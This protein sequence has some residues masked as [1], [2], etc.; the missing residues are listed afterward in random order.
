MTASKRRWPLA[1]SPRIPKATTAVI[2]PAGK[3]GTLKSRLSAIA[4]PTNSAR[5][6]AM[7]MSSAWTHRPQVTGRGK[8][9]RHSSGRLRPGGDA[10]LRRQ[11][12]D[13]HRHQ[14]GGEQ[15]PQQQVAVLGAAGDVRREV[16]RVDVGDAGDERGAEHGQRAAQSDRATGPA[17]GE[18]AAAARQ[19]RLARQADRLI[20]ATSTR[21]ARA[22]APPRTWTSSPKRANVGPSK[23]CLSMTSKSSPGAMPALGQVAQHLRVGVRDAHE[24]RARRRLEVGQRDRRRAPSITRSRRRDRVAVRIERGVAELGRDQLLE[25]LGEGVLEHLGLGVDPV[26]RHV[27]R[28]GE[29][30]LEQPV[31]ADHLEREALAGLGELDAVVGRVR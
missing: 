20:D 17:A 14:V 27:E 3:S 11:V 13:Q 30:E 19:R 10:D 15:D 5:S 9:S 23:G 29:V 22:S 25:L 2:S 4:A 28:L 26:P 12:L 16:A 31:V 6:V 1:C 24:G 8:C 7:A 18:W 21:I